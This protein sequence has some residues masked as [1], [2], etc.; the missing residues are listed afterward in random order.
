M[1]SV[2]AIIRSLMALEGQRASDNADAG[3]GADWLESLMKEERDEHL[4]RVSR[5]VQDGLFANPP[6]RA[7][8]FLAAGATTVAGLAAWM[9]G[10][11]SPALAQVGGSYLGGFLI[12]WACRRALKITA[13]IAGA[14]L[15][16]IG[17]LK[18]SGWIDVNWSVIEQNVS[19]N[20]AWLHGEAESLKQLLTGYLPSVG[21]G[22]AGAFFGFRKKS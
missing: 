18:S 20:L 13:L 7:K 15:A 22:T 10:M 1:L 2:T 11:M 14:L 16:L 19:Q 3:R 6:W 21:A 5:K 4:A 12:G 8:S 17:L 9:N